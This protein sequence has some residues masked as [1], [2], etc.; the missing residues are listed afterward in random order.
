VYKTIS[1]KKFLDKIYKELE[2]EV[3][4]H[5]KEGLSQPGFLINISP[6]M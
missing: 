3:A 5:D 2:I 6:G 1:S 4:R